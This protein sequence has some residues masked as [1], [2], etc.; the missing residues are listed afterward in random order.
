[1]DINE[2]T[3]YVLRLKEEV[4]ELGKENRALEKRVEELESVGAVGAVQVSLLPKI[5]MLNVDQA[6]ELFWV[7]TPRQH[8]FIQLILEGF[9]NQEIADRLNSSLSSIKTRFRHLCGRLSIKGR[10]D[11]EAN[12]K[13]IFEYADDQRYLANAKIAKTWA[14]EYAKLAF[15]QAKKKDPYFKIICETNYRGVSM[16]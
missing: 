12:Y 10:A 16:S 13:P 14:A 1:M 7:C 2:L 15:K 5:K 3:D 8:A 6:T 11:L 9:S 4:G